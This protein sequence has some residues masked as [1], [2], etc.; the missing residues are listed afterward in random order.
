M[1]NH[2]IEVNKLSLSFTSYGRG[3]SQISTTVLKELSL[4]VDAG[5]VYAL[6]GSSGSGKSLLAESIL[7][8]LPKNAETSGDIS[9]LGKALGVGEL[10]QLRGKEIVYV[11]QGV[12][13]LDPLLKVKPQLLLTKEMEERKSEAFET[14]ELG[15]E[16]DGLYPFE[17]SGGMARRVLVSTALL[18]DAKI[19]VADE[20]TPGMTREQARRTLQFFKDMARD[21]KAVLLITHDLDLALEIADTIGVFHEGSLVEEAKRE[22]F[23]GDGEALKSELARRLWRALPQ[24]EFTDALDQIDTSQEYTS[25]DAAQE[26]ILEARHISYSYPGQKEPVLKDVSFSIRSGELVGL[27]GGSGTGKSTLAQILSGLI[28]A[29]EGDV[30]FDG[31][32]VRDMVNSVANPV[33]LIYQHPELA[34][35]PRWRMKKVLEEVGQ[36]NKDLLEQAGIKEEWLKRYSYE[37]SGGELQRFCV[38]RAL[39]PST[40]VLICDEISTMLDAYTQAHIWNVLTSYAQAHNLSL[41]IISHNDALLNKLCDK[42]IKL[43]NL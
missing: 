34:I 10:S 13:N 16:V 23:Y 22:Q 9:F 25:L 2:V 19:I 24:N 3:L 12:T 1:N 15:D 27:Y 5:E 14:L 7:G 39:M 21:G 29:S 20:P 37:L 32:P 11:P 40:K 8:I 28:K 38:V 30:L 18:V 42:I 35:N 33:Q 36:D 26:H 31:K 17:L 41:L 4:S 43:E 6:V